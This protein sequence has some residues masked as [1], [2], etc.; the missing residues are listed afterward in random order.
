MG[1][2]RI[3]LVRMAQE[4]VEDP[5]EA[6]QTIIQRIKDCGTAGEANTLALET[7]GARAGPDMAAAIREGRLDL[8]TFLQTLKDSP[9]IIND[10]AEATYDLEEQFILLKNKAFTALEPLGQTFMDT[11]EDL[12]PSFEGLID[13]IKTAVDWFDNLSPGAQRVLLTFLGLLAASGPLI[14]GISGIAKSI[15]TV[16]TAVLALSA[17][18]KTSMLLKGGVWAAAIALAITQVGDSVQYTG[19]NMHKLDTIIY[20]LGSGFDRIKEGSEGYNEEVGKMQDEQVELLNQLQDLAAEYPSVADEVIKLYDQWKNG[21]ITLEEYNDGLKKILDNKDDLV[22]ANQDLTQA[23]AD[24]VQQYEDLGYTRDEAISLAR[25]EVEVLEQIEEAADNT[26]DATEDLTE[27]TEDLI[28]SIFK[29]YNLTQSVTEAN[30]KYEDAL[31]DYNE[32]MKNSEATD[33]EKQ[34]ALYGVQDRLED[35]LGAIQREYI[36]EGTSIERKKELQQEMANVGTA[37]VEMGLLSEQAFV[38]MAYQFGLSGQDIID[39]AE[40]VGIELDEATKERIVEVDVD[41]SKVGPA[42]A[43]IG[44]SLSRI[45]HKITTEVVVYGPGMPSQPSAKVSVPG[46]QH[47]LEVIREGQVMVGERGP[48]LL[49][50]NKGAKVIPLEKR[51]TE[52]SITNIFEIAELVVREKADTKLIAEELQD[53]QEKKMRGLGKKIW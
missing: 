1:S 16:R 28:E 48:E 38:D 51:G 18:E 35:L 33:R 27:A 47:G 5:A 22:S 42:V 25:G 53:M 52:M 9:E 21:T 7:F 41:Y 13:K 50:L 37:A 31:K 3:A 40:D 20:R 23:E 49:E 19:D 2:L 44:K 34:E 30:W 11:I 46:G 43:Q 6:L 10:A 15:M 29:L 32:T 8:D 4:G 45:P 36:E 12:M 39:M 26:T 24:L 14:I 17:A